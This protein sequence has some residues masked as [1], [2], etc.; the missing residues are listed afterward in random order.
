[1]NDTD[2]RSDA[3]RFASAHGEQSAGMLDAFRGI[4]RVRK[5][6]ARPSGRRNGSSIARLLGSL[7]ALA[8]LSLPST[9]SAHLV[10]TRFGELYSGMLHPLTTLA[11]VVPS[12]GL[13]LLGGLQSG[14]SARWAPWVLPAGAAAGALLGALLPASPLVTQLNVVS[15]V[16]LGLLVALAVELNPALFI[17]LNAAVG[18]SHGYANAASSLQGGAQALYLL[19]VASAAYGLVTLVAG[20]AQWLR[21]RGA[22]G[23]IALRAAGSWIVAIGLVFGGFSLMNPS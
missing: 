9:A 16:A 21:R 12:F 2:R 3:V 10:S 1:M 6:R 17:S 15:F 4:V 19:G 8:L 20:A 11:H 5:P 13:G 18:L 23:T 14:S 7:T 22:W